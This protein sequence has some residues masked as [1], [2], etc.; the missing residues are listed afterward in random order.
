[1]A[2]Y[3]NYE[4]DF[5]GEYS[6][7]LGKEVS[8]L[9]NVPAGM[10]AKTLPAAK[11]GVFTSERGPIPAIVIDLWK[12]IWG[13]KP[14]QIGGDRAYIGDFEVYDGRSSD[15]KSAQIDLFLSIK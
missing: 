11:Y 3:T 12:F 5:N 7:I 15:P 14:G 2:V 10:T 1:M 9:E 4:S 8:S 6:F 13:I